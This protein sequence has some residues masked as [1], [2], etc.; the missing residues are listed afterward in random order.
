MHKT[1]KDFEDMANSRRKKRA[2]P[3]AVI[4]SVSRGTNKETEVIPLKLLKQKLRDIFSVG[5]RNGPAKCL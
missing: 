3:G 2:W 1:R 4:Q 5:L